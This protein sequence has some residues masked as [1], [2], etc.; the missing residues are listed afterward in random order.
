MPNCQLSP[1]TLVTAEYYL[2]ASDNNVSFFEAKTPPG[3]KLLEATSSP[4]PSLSCI[5]SKKNKQHNTQQ[6]TDYFRGRV[7]RRY[8]RCSVDESE[9]EIPAVRKSS[10][11]A[12]I[13]V[14][15]AVVNQVLF[16]SSRT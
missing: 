2:P 8:R 5:H 4:S 6:Q 15:F 13:P 10:S 12:D 7:R 1:I 14:E 9:K 11:L 16:L 3:R